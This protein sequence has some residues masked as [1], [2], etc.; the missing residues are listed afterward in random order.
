[1]I[2]V[3]YVISDYR[4]KNS[5]DVLVETKF[6]DELILAYAF[7]IVFS[8]KHNLPYYQIISQFSNH[9]S[10]ATD[11]VDLFESIPTNYLKDNNTDYVF[12]SEMGN[13]WD[14]HEI[15]NL[16]IGN[17]VSNT[18]TPLGELILLRFDEISEYVF[19]LLNDYIYAC[20]SLD[21][22]K[23]NHTVLKTSGFVV[24]RSDSDTMYLADSITSELLGIKKLVT[25]HDIIEF[26]ISFDKITEGINKPTKLELLESET[27]RYVANNKRRFM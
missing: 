24:T 10:S 8:A 6:T 5:D 19:D 14:S 11:S 20:F 23:I 16:S 7:A 27:N 22:S 17:S 2:V 4:S 25:C 15:S 26:S 18:L 9:W 3:K 21:F 1:M 13:G 12:N